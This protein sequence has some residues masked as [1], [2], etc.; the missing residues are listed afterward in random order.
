M[1]FRSLMKIRL[2]QQPLADSLGIGS[3]AH[4]REQ[5][6]RLKEMLKC[7]EKELSTL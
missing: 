3:N 6:A 1:L 7:L 5:C 4:S 2:M